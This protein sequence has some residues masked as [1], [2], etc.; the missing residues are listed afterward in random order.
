MLGAWV[1]DIDPFAL[2]LWSG[3]GLRWYGLA[4]VAGF[5][6][7][8]LLVRWII[9]RGLTPLP[10]ARA[11]DFV[12]FSAIAG[13]VGGRLGYA[14]LYRPDLFVSF[15]PR[16][17]FWDLLDI[18]QGGMAS[19]GGMAGAA[20]AAWWFGRGFKGPEGQ[21]RI[22]RAGFLHYA[23]VMAL[24]APPGLALGRLA[25]FV[26]GELLGRVV[27]PPGEPAPRWSVKFPQEIMSGHRP[28][29]EL[30]PHTSA[31]LEEIVRPHAPP[32]FAPGQ[33]DL[34]AGYDQVVGHIQRGGELGRQLTEQLAPLL[35]ARHP[36]QLYQAV[37]EGLLLG[38]VLWAVWYRPRVPGVIAGTFLITYGLGRIATEYW[39]LPDAHLRVQRAMGLSRGQWL[40]AAMVVGGI[41]LLVW[42]AGRARRRRA[43]GEPLPTYGGWGPRR[44]RVGADRRAAGG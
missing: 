14:L 43:R 2:E 7:A 28:L 29:H 31:R 33:I 20:L 25:N 6:I 13:V 10:A 16:L 41:V 21:G 11:G 39:R 36:S 35:A 3:F 27:A 9:R 37:V 15:S 26:N 4:Y 40:S 18:T 8:Y 12:L 32:D 34:V 17:P 22:A 1:H 19:H 38:I 24:V 23:E 44:T 5:L 30:D 42:V